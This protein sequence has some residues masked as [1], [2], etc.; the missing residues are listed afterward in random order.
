M[1]NCSVCRRKKLVELV[2][3]GTAVAVAARVANMSRETAYKWLARFA[4]DEEEGLK[5]ASRARKDP[6]QFKGELADRFLQLRRDHPTWGAGKLRDWMKP[7]TNLPLPAES[8]VQALL[9]RNGLIIPRQRVQRHTPFRYAGKAPDEPNV[10]W[11]MDFK[12][13]F[14]VGDGTKCLPFTL[15]DAASRRLLEIKALPTTA[16]APVH[17]ILERQFRKNGLPK[18]L[19]S[20]GGGPFATTGLSCLSRLS[21]WLLKLGVMPV[22]SRPAKPQDNGGH[23]RMHRDLKAETTRPP[24]QTME[25]QQKKFDAFRHLFNEERPHE[26]LGGDVPDAHWEPSPRAFPSRI[27]KPE[28][29]GAW[30][31]RRVNSAAHTISWRDKVVKVNDALSGEDIAFEPVDEGVWCVYF[32]D[33]AIGLLQEHDPKPKFVSMPRISGHLA[34]RQTTSEP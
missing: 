19:Q 15:R 7:R 29:P 25:G 16:S 10:R 2:N 4:T 13:D 28:Y 8:T 33:Y 26:A 21:V 34:R 3:E 31:V 17:A 23:E 18:E 1:E 32:Y 6:G 30:E 24:A 11:T 12:G 14:R 22:L 20:D 5:D 9:K 27:S